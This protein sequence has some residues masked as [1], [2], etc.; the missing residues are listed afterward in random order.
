[1]D[2]HGKENVIQC[3]LEALNTWVECYGRFFG[4]QTA[5]GIARRQ[6]HCVEG[7][8]VLRSNIRLEVRFLRHENH[9]SIIYLS[10]SISGYCE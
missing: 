8:A 4:A 2:I 3:F 5:A 10:D 1:M 9:I 6:V 7:K